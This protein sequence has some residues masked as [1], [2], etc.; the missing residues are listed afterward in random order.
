MIKMLRDENCVVLT[1]VDS[2][3]R[4]YGVEKEGDTDH[5]CPDRHRGAR[6]PKHKQ[7]NE[8]LL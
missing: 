2:E 7:R 6:H 8:D 4:F 3:Y 5:D 1:L